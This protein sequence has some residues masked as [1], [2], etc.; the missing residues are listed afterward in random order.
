MI[1][2]RLFGALLCLF[3]VIA[4]S[5]GA[6]GDAPSPLDRAFHADF[7]GTGFVDIANAITSHTGVKLGTY[8]ADLP[9]IRNAAP[10]YLVSGRTS[11]RTVM[12]CLAFRFSFRY[13]LSET[14]VLELSTGYGWAAGEPALKILRLDKTV[15]A[16]SKPEALHPLLMECVKPV[17]LTP[18]DYSLSFERYPTRENPHGVRCLAV[19]PPVL[20]NYLERAVLCLEG[21]SGDYP[22]FT[23]PGL[24]AHAGTAP[25]DW[26]GILSRPITVPLANDLRGILV[27]ITGQ[28]ATAIALA[29]PPNASSAP[30]TGMDSR[31]GLG[32]VSGLLAVRYGLGQRTM[33][34]GG[35][36]VYAPGQDGAMA[37]DNRSRELYWTGLAVAGFD[38]ARAAERAGGG[39]NLK[40]AIRRKVFPELWRDPAC[41]IVYSPASGRLAV[42]APANAVRAVAAKIHDLTITE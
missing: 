19:L 34:A 7:W 8:P 30:L 38:A 16:G 35:G 4:R 42:I 40:M 18:G 10:I 5:P 13:R 21:D 20:A 9:E 39:D 26:N 1:N 17:A 36:I 32:I 29:V 11:L 27:D 12:E 31:T 24:H 14:G 37:L 33:L 6:A 25:T 28:S 2:R 22:D 15:P 3:L 23:R 41:A